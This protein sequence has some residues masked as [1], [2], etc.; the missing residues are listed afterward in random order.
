MSIFAENIFTAAETEAAVQR[1]FPYARIAAKC[2]SKS[3][4]NPRHWAHHIRFGFFDIGVFAYQDEASGYPIGHVNVE[5]TAIEEQV[6]QEWPDDEPDEDDL[7]EEG[8]TLWQKTG[9][10]LGELEEILGGVREHLM[11]IAAAITYVSGKPPQTA[12][13]GGSQSND[14]ALRPRTAR[15]RVSGPN[16]NLDPNEPSVADAVDAFVD[17]LNKRIQKQGGPPRIK[18]LPASQKSTAD[19]ISGLLD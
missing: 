19:P 11:G 5:L 4:P 18:P 10:G 2:Y 8:V 13:M 7:G 15:R 17:N 9:V 16:L 6:D 3:N 12:H 14:V 1:T